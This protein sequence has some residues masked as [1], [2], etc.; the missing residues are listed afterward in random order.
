MKKIY[1]LLP[2]I[3]VIF[4]FTSC[5]RRMESKSAPQSLPG[6]LKKAS[7]GAQ[8]DKSMVADESAKKTDIRQNRKIVR[9]ASVSLYL[10]NFDKGSKEIESITRQYSGVVANKSVQRSTYSVYGTMT[11]WVPA[12]KLKEFIEKIEKVG[13][14]RSSQMTAE[15]ISDQYY[16]LE[17]RLRSKTKQ[18]ERLL[19]MLDKE[20]N[21]LDHLL[22]LEQELARVRGEVETMEGRKRRWDQ[23]VTYSTVTVT[24]TQDIQAAREPDDIWKPFRRAIRDIKPTF[25]SSVGVF[26]KFIGGI[27]LL[28]V[29]LIPWA[30]ALFILILI[31]K[32]LFAKRW[33]AYRERKRK[34]KEQRK[35]R[36]EVNVEKK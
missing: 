28:A 24:L 34:E 17:A 30:I 11:L 18:E 8:Y 16:D 14:V 26:I 15:D 27:V 3:I 25:I 31:W 22:K 23:Q 6:S 20:G 4:L 12:E 13:K 9:T 10:E 21:S 1:Y 7:T 2:I 33:S 5:D 32:L 29:A 35:N 19:S 36:S